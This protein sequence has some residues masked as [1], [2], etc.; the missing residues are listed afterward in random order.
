[1]CVTVANDMTPSSF[2]LVSVFDEQQ[3]NNEFK[4]IT[5]GTKKDSTEEEE[6]LESGMTS[7]NEIRWNETRSKY[8]RY[9]IN[10]W[11]ESGWLEGTSARE[12]AARAEA[13]SKFVVR[14]IAGDAASGPD[15]MSLKME[16]S[17]RDG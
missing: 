12:R 5:A 15:G 6:E 14:S 4:K 7:R 17:A 2:V 13:A 11:K 10:D 8:I 3:P 1:M 9:K 16:E